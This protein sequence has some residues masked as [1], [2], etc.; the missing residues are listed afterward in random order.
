M[1]H[2]SYV[3][4]AFSLVFYF[5]F[6]VAVRFME[7]TPK[8]RNKARLIILIISAMTFS[9]STLCAGILHLYSG[10]YVYGAIFLI[11]AASSLIFVVA[12]LIE[13]HQINAR[14]KMR[15]FMVLFDIVDRYIN[16]GKSR[17]EIMT[18]LT[19]NQKLSNKEAT[20]FL[21]FI[22]DPTNHQFLSDVNEKIQ[23]AKLMQK[24]ETDYFR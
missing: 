10:A 1:L 17:E 13:L 5:V 18:Y 19:G 23:E 6:G 4:I 20:D 22:S 24:V 9:I 21:E 11:L 15:R 7:L 8:S 16:E 12:I 3:G 14:V 2:L